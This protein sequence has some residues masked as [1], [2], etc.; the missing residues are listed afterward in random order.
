M[1]E[2]NAPIGRDAAIDAVAT[3]LEATGTPW[4][5]PEPGHF[6]VTLPGEC[7]LATTCSIVVGEHSVSVQAFVVRRPDEN[8]AAVHRW[9]LERNLRVYGVAYALDAH[10]DVFLAGRLPHAAVTPA[11]VDR[12]LGSVLL[13]ADGALNTLLELG[14]GESIRREWEW[15]RKRG[16]ST[17]NLAAFAHLARPSQD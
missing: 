16:E 3:A 17:A 4:E 10:G 9:L 5:Q 1:T 12:V 8:A 6:V 14:F 2:G 15:R 13:E 7:K 11:E